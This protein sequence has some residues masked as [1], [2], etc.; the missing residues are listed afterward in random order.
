MTAGIAATRPA[1]VAIRDS[2]MPGA[3]IVSDAAPADP[4][5]IKEVMIPQTVPNRPIKGVVEPVVARKLRYFSSFADSRAPYLLR[6]LFV[7]VFSLCTSSE[8]TALNKLAIG[9]IIKFFVAWQRPLESLF[10]L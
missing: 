10:D 1:A 8:Y 6:S 7:S 3:T 5:L 4:M 9:L 2:A